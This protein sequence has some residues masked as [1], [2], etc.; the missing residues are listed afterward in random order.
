MSAETTRYL[1]LLEERLALLGSLATAL[2]A[3]RLDIVS[4]DING[5][6]AR[7][8]EQENLCNQIRS[9][10]VQLDRVQRLCVAHI[11]APSIQPAAAISDEFAVRRRAILVR[12]S[13]V[14][15]TVKQLNDE[16]Q[17]LLRRSRR[18]VSALLN[19][20]QTFAMTYSKPSQ[21]RAELPAEVHA[22]AGEG[23]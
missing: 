17:A 19:S 20:Y 8:S 1:Q 14:Q 15:A 13:R 3:A 18:T 2:T 10:D 22:V 23:L 9:L 7:I 16:H 6:E 4:L 12:L 11:G 5:L 21:L